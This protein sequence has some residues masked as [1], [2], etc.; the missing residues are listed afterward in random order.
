MYWTDWEED[1]MNDSRGRI[2]RAWMDGSHRQVFVSSDVLWPNGLTLDRPTETLYWCDA[3]HHRI[4]KI[5]FNGTLRTVS[6]FLS[7]V[8]RTLDTLTAPGYSF[9]REGEGRMVNDRLSLL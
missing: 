8:K 4:E 6:S 2:E 5:H 3:F 7:N 1:E 9:E